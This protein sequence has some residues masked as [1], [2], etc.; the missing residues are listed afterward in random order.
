MQEKSPKKCGV[1]DIP[2]ENL[3]EDSLG[4]EKYVKGLEQFILNCETPMSIALQGDWGTGK[5]SF[6][7]A[8]RS[9]FN[10]DY[11]KIKTVY[12]NTWQ[13][14]QFKMS[15]NLYAS[16]ISNIV[17]ALGNNDSDS[18]TKDKIKSLANNVMKISSRVAK[19]IIKEN[20][21]IDIDELEEEVAK[22][23]IEKAENICNLKND[24]ANIV[25]KVKGEN[26]RVV[27]FVDDL[28]RLNPE[29]AVELLEVMKLFMDVKDCIFVLAI[30]YE[31]VVNGVRKKFGNDMSEDK[32]RSFFDKIIQLPFSMPVGSYHIE[33]MIKDVLGNV[34]NAYIKPLSHFVKSSLG[35]NP[36]TLKRLANSF[37]LL[38][39]V[40]NADDNGERDEELQAALLFASLVVQLYSYEAYA[41]L[42]ENADDLEILLKSFDEAHNKSNNEE[43][44]EDEKANE[45]IGLLK[46]ALDNIAKIAK[47]KPED[48]Y[49]M[50]K[51]AMNISS[52]TSI[53]KISDNSVKE[54]K[55]AMKVTKIRIKGVEYQVKKPT[56]AQIK[57]YEEIL[58]ENTDRIKEFIEKYPRILT[59]DESRKD[60]FF[61]VS[62]QTC[63]KLD[64]KILYIGTSSSSS[65]K[66]IFT[67]ALCD[68]MEVESGSVV[69]Y[70]G[71]EEVFSN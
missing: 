5:T 14:S 52:I 7:Q 48:I 40:A 27:I 34:I 11:P 68:F 57:T 38:R 51:V 31:V 3:V 1:A 16:F 22:K 10:K 18:D 32:C 12:F 8:M 35:A 70:D 63:V 6:L 23:E 25:K 9:D 20:T 13:Y 47:I 21:N 49:N 29:I 28:D 53:A 46:V 2:C 59:T 43:I 69:W 66:I 26:G 33:D 41:Y 24:F 71:A 44:I 65:D 37:F 4:I 42:T 62:K 30:D 15:E 36:R 61:R 58:K 17:K 64:D 54:R 60:G 67:R 45:I 19:N 50:F 56:Y 39:M 55:K